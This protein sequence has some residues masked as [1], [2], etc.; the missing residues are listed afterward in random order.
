MI[1]HHPEYATTL[2]AITAVHGPDI[3]RLAAAGPA[4]VTAGLFEAIE[5]LE[6]A[7]YWDQAEPL[8]NVLNLLTA[9]QETDPDRA[10]ALLERADRAL[11]TALPAIFAAIG[12]EG[13]AAP[14]PAA[15]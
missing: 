5:T 8:E 3:A 14:A 6:T 10:R 13:P 11:R 4:D 2:A 7:G 1:P 12:E 9:A 15:A